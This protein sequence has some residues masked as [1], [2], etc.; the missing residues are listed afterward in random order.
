VRCIRI[1][2]IG[3]FT[4]NVN[5]LTSCKTYSFHAVAQND[6]SKDNGA[7]K[8]FTPGL[9]IV[10][11]TE[12]SNITP[13]S[14]TLNGNLKHT[15]GTNTCSVWFQYGVSKDQLDQTSDVKTSSEGSFSITLTDLTSCQTYYYQAIADNNICVAQSSMKT[16]SPG[17]PVVETESIGF[18]E[19]HSASL[20]GTLQDFGGTTSCEV[21]FEYGENEDELSFETTHHQ[22]NA[23]GRFTI[24]IS[25]LKTHTKYYY[26]A[27]AD[28]SICTAYG[29]TQTFMTT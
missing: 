16:F 23:I 29:S 1:R 13:T 22:I 11:S 10:K 26:R 18:G 25:D 4:I 17:T 9:P 24:S 7:T 19:E 21:Y 20:E 28:N 8:E 15:G 6:V 14:I 3:Y 5:D 2:I 12:P 27:V